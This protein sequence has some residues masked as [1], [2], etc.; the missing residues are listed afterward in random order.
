VVTRLTRPPRSVDDPIVA[1]AWNVS[2]AGLLMVSPEMG[3][4]QSGYR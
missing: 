3:D 4:D 1:K 2:L